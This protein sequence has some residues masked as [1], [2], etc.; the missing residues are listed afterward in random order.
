MRLNEILEDSFQ[1]VD[2]N[3][4]NKNFLVLFLQVKELNFILCH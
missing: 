4:R 2:R 1:N 3:K